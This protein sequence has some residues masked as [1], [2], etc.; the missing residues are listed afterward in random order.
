MN[1]NPLGFKNIKPLTRAERSAQRDKVALE[2]QRL[3]N[4]SREKA[5][6]GKEPA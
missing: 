5:R 1:T 2:K 6:V 3:M 4:V